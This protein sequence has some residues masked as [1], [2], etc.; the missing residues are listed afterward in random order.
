MDDLTQQLLEGLDAFHPNWRQQYLT[1]SL[2]VKAA[3]LD[4]LF[5]KWK[6]TELGAKYLAKFEGVPDHVG[7]SR[8]E[9]EAYRRPQS[10]PFGYDNIGSAMNFIGEE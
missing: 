7:D 1:L 10:L 5:A 6:N 2:A 8:R 4:S 3:G 9:V